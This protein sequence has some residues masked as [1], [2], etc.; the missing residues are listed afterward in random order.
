MDQH[1]NETRMADEAIEPIEAPSRSAKHARLPIIAAVLTPLLPPIGALL[2]HLALRLTRARQVLSWG[3]II[4][5]WMMTA[6]MVVGAV[7]Y[8]EARGEQE[9]FAEAQQQRQEQMHQAI[10]DSPST[11]R[12]SEEF[13]TAF[14]TAMQASPPSGYIT[15]PE[16]LNDELLAAY[17]ELAQIESPHSQTYTAYHQYLVQI[18]TAEELDELPTEQEHQESAEQLDAALMDDVPACVPVVGEIP[19]HD[20]AD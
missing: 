5:G 13:C 17:E 7:L 10:E 6:V 9:A 16:Q 11:G 3:A 19:E 20:S 14:V 15:H 1:S 8:F 4:I 2:G 18:D 12:V